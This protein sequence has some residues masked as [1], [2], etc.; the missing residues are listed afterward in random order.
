MGQLLVLRE[1]SVEQNV[2]VEYIPEYVGTGMEELARM[3]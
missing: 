3:E 1:D 2:F